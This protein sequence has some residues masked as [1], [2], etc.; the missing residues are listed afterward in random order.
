VVLSAFGNGNANYHF[1]ITE[2]LVRVI[3][4]NQLPIVYVDI[5]PG[6]PHT[7]RLELHWD[8][9][10]AWFVDD[11]LI[12]SGTPFGLYPRP[13]SR[14]IWGARYYL[15]EHTTRWD[16]VRYGTIPEPGTGVLFLVALG[17]TAARRSRRR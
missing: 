10:Y 12:D 17:L 5:A 2:D 16:Y 11:Q 3:R 14:I 15:N 1:T 6:V 4:D 9:L 13:D 7:Y 8:E